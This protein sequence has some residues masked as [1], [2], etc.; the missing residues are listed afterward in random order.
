MAA[1][2]VN[3]VYTVRIDF[4]EHATLF[5]ATCETLDKGAGNRIYLSDDQKYIEIIYAADG[6]KVVIKEG[7]FALFEDKHGNTYNSMAELY[8]AL[9]SFM[10]DRTGI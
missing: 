2:F 3:R 4:N 6:Q 9:D 7:G 10:E 5:S 1:V 8:N